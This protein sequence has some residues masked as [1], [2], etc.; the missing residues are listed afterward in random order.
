M[1]H[2]GMFLSGISGIKCGTTVPISL[3]CLPNG[4]IFL[5]DFLLADRSIT[6]YFV[7]MMVGDG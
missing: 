3:C 5:M 1:M 7:S 6:N 4:Y 2:S